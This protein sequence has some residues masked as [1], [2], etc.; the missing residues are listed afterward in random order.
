LCVCA[1]MIS[2]GGRKLVDVVLWAPYR[3][4]KPIGPFYDQIDARHDA[5]CYCDIVLRR[6]FIGF[7]YEVI[8]ANRA[9]SFSTTNALYPQIVM[10]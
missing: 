4:R 6:W 2:F 1:Q 3:R 10:L 7:V 5:S 9:V 8:L